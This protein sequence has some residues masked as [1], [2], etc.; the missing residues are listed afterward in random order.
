MTKHLLKVY[1]FLF[2]VAGLNYQVTAQANKTTISGIRFLE[3][4]FQ[5]AQATAKAAKKQLFV[6]V[7][8]TGCPHCEAIAPIFKEKQVGDFYNTHFVSWKTEANSE[9]SKS[10]QNAKG[11]TYPEFPLFFFFDGEGNLLHMGTPEEKATKAEFVEEV[12]TQGKVA[13]KPE[14]RTS[15]FASRFQNGERDLTFLIKYGKYARAVKDV[16]VSTTIGAEMGKVLV[17]PEDIKS[18]TGF[19]IIQ[20]LIQDFDNPLAKY[21]FAHL[22]EFRK[23]Y[24]EKEVKDAGEAIIYHSLYGPKGDVHPQEKIF[25]MRQAMVKL[26]VTPA[27]AASRTL[28]KE[29]DACMREKN[30]KKAVEF[31][32]Q[33]RQL[34]PTLGG[35]DYAYLMKYFNE[36]ATDNSYLSEMAGWG[37]SG[38]KATKPA[39][40]AM[41]ITA[42]INLE[43]GEAYRKMGKKTEATTYAQ[44]AL[45]SAKLAK[46][47]TEP[48]EELL[49]KLKKM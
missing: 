49:D 23:L 1:L 14:E 7:Y 13:L 10:L 41:Q 32:N 33:Y 39:D 40:M 19:Y 12:L 16:A 36:K 21:F 22:D 15:N 43:L 37:A 45:E 2:L 20:R 11:L 28:L 38:L 29:L 8:L 34:T 3:G 4:T 17:T 42:N 44:K 48:F 24:G 26:G 31:F 47:K 35:A 6:E 25:E 30:T 18:Q 46:M 9:A 27:E 5:A